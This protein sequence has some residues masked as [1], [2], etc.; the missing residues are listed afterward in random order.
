[1]NIVLRCAVFLTIFILSACNVYADEK[2]V[3]AICNKIRQ[4]KVPVAYLLDENLHISSGPID[5]GRWVDDG[6][7]DNALIDTK[8][9]I[10]I[11]PERIK[12]LNNDC[13]DYGCLKLERSKQLCTGA[14]TYSV[15]VRLLFRRRQDGF[16][17]YKE[18]SEFLPLMIEDPKSDVESLVYRFN[19]RLKGNVVAPDGAKNP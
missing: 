1:M 8:Y 9:R 5:Y 16:Y 11:F 10:L 2:N 18:D 14:G 7:S 19:T 3:D 15:S 6:K 12:F 13:F 4:E 17:N